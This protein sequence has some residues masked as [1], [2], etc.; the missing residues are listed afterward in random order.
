MTSWTPQSAAARRGAI[1]GTLSV[2][3]GGKQE[4]LERARPVLEVLGSK[5]TYMGGSGK[6]Q[7]TKLCNQV[8]VGL[9]MIAAGEALALGEAF[10]LDASALA[11]SDQR[12]CRGVVDAFKPRPE[13]GRGGLGSRFSDCPAAE[14]PAACDGIGL[15][16]QA[17]TYGYFAHSP[18]LHCRGVSGLGRR[19]H[20]GDYQAY[21]TVRE[22]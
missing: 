19:G 1:A 10:G 11:G 6:G 16:A 17:A 18:A 9:S 22:C 21:Q 15:H 12:R 3:V 13:D 20:T 2:M 8:A 5:I 14:R 7:A 4:V